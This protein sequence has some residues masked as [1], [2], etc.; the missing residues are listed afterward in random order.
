[1]G[2]AL[3]GAGGRARVE[4]LVVVERLV[5]ELEGRARGEAARRAADVLRRGP[6]YGKGKIYDDLPPQYRDNVNKEPPFSTPNA[7]SEKEMDDIIAFLAT[8]EDGYVPRTRR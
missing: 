8:L 1:V 4:A 3:V 5:V 2:G 6:W 7:L